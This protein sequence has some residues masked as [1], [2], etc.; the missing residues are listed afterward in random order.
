M[1]ALLFVGWLVGRTTSELHDLR[2][3]F[4]TMFVRN[5]YIGIDVLAVFSTQSTIVPSNVVGVLLSGF[6][7]AG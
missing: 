2:L 7:Y 1:R 6:E 3:S 5:R 4:A